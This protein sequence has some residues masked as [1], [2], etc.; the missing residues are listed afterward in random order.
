MEDDNIIEDDN[1]ID[2]LK[3]LFKEETNV[4]LAG[5][6]TLH[7]NEKQESDKTATKWNVRFFEFG[8]FYVF[9]ILKLKV[10]SLFIGSIK[11]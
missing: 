5:V 11:R 9:V 10:N 4:D 3:W 2:I 1:V 8:I 6:L 7:L